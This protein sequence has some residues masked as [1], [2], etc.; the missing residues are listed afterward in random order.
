[1]AVPSGIHFIFTGTHAGVSGLTG[2]TRNTDFDT[3]YILGAVTDADGGTPGGAAH[4]H[5]ATGGSHTHTF[6]FSG[7]TGGNALLAGLGKTYNPSTH[8]HASTTSNAASLVYGEGSNDQDR[9]NI[10]VVESGGTNDIPNTVSAFFDD[11]DDLSAA[12]GWA[13]NNGSGGRPDTRDAILRGANTDGDSGAV[14]GGLD[15]HTH[16]TDHAHAQKASARAQQT[17]TGAGSNLA[18]ATGGRTGHY[19]NV[20]LN[21]GGATTAS[22]DGTPPWKKLVLAMNQTGGDDLPDQ[23]IGMWDGAHASIGVGDYVDWARVTTQDDWFIKTASGAGQIGATDGNETH[24]HTVST[25]NHTGSGTSIGQILGNKVGGIGSWSVAAHSHTWTV[26]LNGATT[27]AAS[28]KYTDY[29]SY[30]TVIFIK[31][32]KPAGV[33]FI[34][35]LTVL[36]AG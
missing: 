8:S 5:H 14:A 23:V 19:H 27:S 28:V 36:G 6:T 22:N 20:V 33:S 12:T 35:R 3:R 29:P 2:Y 17:G 26:Q 31:Y 25:H 15:A 7:A 11:G 1:M 9:Y 13:E 16:S 18:Y 21:T 34:P 10:I 4:H 24:T 30:R 32:T